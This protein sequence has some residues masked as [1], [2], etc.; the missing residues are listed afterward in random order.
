MQVFEGA[1]LYTL[2]RVAGDEALKVI[3]HHQQLGTLA[4]WY[5]AFAA[6]QA[7][8]GVDFGLELRNKADEAFHKHWADRVLK[9]SQQDRLIWEV[10]NRV[11][12]TINRAELLSRSGEKK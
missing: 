7:A 9:S 4:S 2:K 8:S 6:R 12:R 1:S 10:L 11:H 5:G 3:N